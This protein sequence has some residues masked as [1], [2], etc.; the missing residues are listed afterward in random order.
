MQFGF[1]RY[2]LERYGLIGLVNYAAAVHLLAAFVVVQSVRHGSALSQWPTLL[3]LAL[4]LAGA[5]CLSIATALVFYRRF[6]ND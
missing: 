3:D 2:V 6:K 4:T 1:G 5:L